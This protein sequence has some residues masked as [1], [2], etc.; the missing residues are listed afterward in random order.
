MVKS[1]SCLRIHKC[2]QKLVFF[3]LCRCVFQYHFSSPHI[4][5][6]K[7][8]IWDF[9]VTTFLKSTQFALICS[10]Y[11]G[12]YSCPRLIWKKRQRQ[13]SGWLTQKD[14][15]DLIILELQ[16]HLETLTITR[17]VFDVLHLLNPVWILV[18]HMCVVRQQS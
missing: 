12:L 18:C 15:N 2:V 8:K 1:C 5:S 11:R 16:P 4:P 14:V 13:E 9:W 17:P 3:H 7:E 6:W 10:M